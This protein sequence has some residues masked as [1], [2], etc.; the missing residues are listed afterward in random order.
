MEKLE[1][2]AKNP[3]RM[4][5]VGLGACAIR[6]HL[7]SRAFDTKTLIPSL[8]EQ[9]RQHEPVTQA[10]E[11]L[12]EARA[13]SSARDRDTQYAASLARPLE[14]IPF[15]IKDIIETQG[16]PTRMGSPLFADYVPE[17]SAPVIRALED[18]GAIILGKTV[19]TEFATQCP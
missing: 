13:I 8:L 2:A 14:G 12:D 16:V 5:G 11:W 1:P 19:T 6:A 15:G 9:I 10:W 7:E 18:A 17:E 4:P 3:S